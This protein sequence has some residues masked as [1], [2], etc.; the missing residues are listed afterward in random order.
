MSAAR[1]AFVALNDTSHSMS[2]LVQLFVIVSRRCRCDRR[3]SGSVNKVTWL[4]VNFGHCEGAENVPSGLEE[5]F[6]VM[7]S[8]K[9]LRRD[10]KLLA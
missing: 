8:K 2:S 1:L 3:W 7:G 6:E 10:R 9:L 4:K 5:I